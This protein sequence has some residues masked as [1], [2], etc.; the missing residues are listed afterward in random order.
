MGWSL[1]SFHPPLP[2]AAA[3]FDLVYAVRVFSHLDRGLTA[4]WLEELRRVLAPDGLALL[5]VHGP[6][7]FER[8]RTGALSTSWCAPSTFRRAPLAA[9][10]FV[11]AP[12]RRSF[13][14]DGDLPGVGR[15]YGLAF[16]G[17]DHARALWRR[18]LQVVEV[19][20]RALT[21]WQDVVVAVKC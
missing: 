7:A 13:W 8:F 9:D 17:A 15:E 2:Y 10:E 21:D 1:T 11:F 6:A 14:T 19:R 16:H 18:S 3:S 4:L 20:P 5:S 12:Y